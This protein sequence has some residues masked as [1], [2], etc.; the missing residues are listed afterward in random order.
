MQRLLRPP[1]APAL[2]RRPACRAQGHC[3]AAAHAPARG[4]PRMRA[5]HRRRERARRV[6]AVAAAWR[7]VLR[8]AAAGALLL[9]LAVDGP[10]VLRAVS[11]RH[12]F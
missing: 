11:S 3:R 1:P 4:I 6:A 9:H 5:A 10:Q 8:G 7:A 2:R 12:T